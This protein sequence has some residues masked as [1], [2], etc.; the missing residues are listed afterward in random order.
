MKRRQILLTVVAAALV[1]SISVGGAWAYFTA[2]TSASGG[3][4]VKAGPKTDITEPDVSAWTKHVVITN[5]EDSPSVFARARAYAGA[6]YTLTYS[7]EGW[8]DGGDGW[9]YCDEAIAPGGESPELLI[10]I[11]NIP[12]KPEDGQ[13]FNVQ[14]VYEATPALYDADGNPAPDWELKLDDGSAE[15]GN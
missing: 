7:G 2:T 3:V 8:T 15:G 5:D 1:L 9:W 4:T 13:S 12:E 11:G 6:D 10:A 14:V